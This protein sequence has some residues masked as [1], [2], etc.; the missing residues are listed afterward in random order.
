[1]T[2][3]YSHTDGSSREPLPSNQSNADNTILGVSSGAAAGAFLVTLGEAVLPVASVVGSA[4]AGPLLGG[5]VGAAVGA[6]LSAWLSRRDGRP[7]PNASSG[8]L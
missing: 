7:D 3:R 1:M 6:G 8:R 2:D 4:I 5:I